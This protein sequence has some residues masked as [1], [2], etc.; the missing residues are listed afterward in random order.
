MTWQRKRDPISG[1]ARARQSL[2]GLS[3]GDAFGETFFSHPA[4]VARRFELELAAPPPWFYTDDTEMA[5]SIFAVLRERGGIEQDA[6]AASFARRYQPWRG[7]GPAMYH[8]LDALRAGEAWRA[9]APSLFGGQGSFGNGSAMRVAPLGAYFAGDTAA[10]VEHARRSAAV[11]HAHPEAAA[12]AVAVA[13]AAGLASRLGE[14][15]ERLDLGAFIAEVLREVPEGSV[16]A[17]IEQALELPPDSSI[18]RVVRTLGN[19]DLISCQDTVPLCLWCAAKHID[20]YEQ[21]LWLTASGMGD[22]DTNCAIVGGIVA[23]YTGSQAIPDRWLKN[24]EPLP[25]WPFG[26]GI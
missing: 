20:D 3:V 24:R 16:R 22:C 9:V 11:T 18:A 17:G 19:G 7:Y 15:G 13:V 5:L 1:L 14:L 25:P 6:L 10:I 8:L 23:A 12:G 4:A 26:E 21:A 2:E